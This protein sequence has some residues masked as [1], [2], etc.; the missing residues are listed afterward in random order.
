MKILS[1]VISVLAVALAVTG[2]QLP[3]SEVPPQP[4]VAFW[5]DGGVNHYENLST[6]AW[7]TDRS[8]EDIQCVD[9]LGRLAPPQS[10]IVE[11]CKQV[12]PTLK[13]VNATKE[14]RDEEICAGNA[15]CHQAYPYR[16]LVKSLCDD[17]GESPQR[18]FTT[19]RLSFQKHN[20]KL[21]LDVTIID[22]HCQEEFKLVGHPRQ[23]CAFYRESFTVKYFPPSSPSCEPICPNP[24]PVNPQFGKLSLKT[25]EKTGDWTAKYTIN[26]PKGY[27]L[28]GSTIRKCPNNSVWDTPEPF[29]EFTAF[30][31]GQTCNFSSNSGNFDDCVYLNSEK[32]DISWARQVD[33]QKPE[34]LPSVIFP[35]ADK[36]DYYSSESDEDERDKRQ[37]QRVITGRRLILFIGRTLSVEYAIFGVGLFVHPRF[38][39]QSKASYIRFSLSTPGSGLHYAVEV[40]AICIPSG[41]I[42]RIGDDKNEFTSLARISQKPPNGFFCLNLID[43]V[44]HRRCPRFSLQFTVSVVF[45]VQRGT[46]SSLVLTPDGISNSPRH[47]RGNY[48]KVYST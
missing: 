38:N 43:T 15:S 28:R 48:I 23:Y 36:C 21:L 26:C 16:C 8:S 7:E 45:P 31:L 22:Y 1:Q 13:I 39:Q 6:G 46:R 18:G 33:G 30:P 4:R 9:T 37:L 32:N 11:F 47:C 5:C 2:L 41:S 35:D 19:E 42:D 24:I 20:I 27:K 34:V 44:N 25:N 29:C 10:V 12:Y 3:F 40:H 14:D 17:V